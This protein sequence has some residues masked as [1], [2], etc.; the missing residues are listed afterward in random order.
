MTDKPQKQATAETNHSKSSL[1]NPQYQCL[2]ELLVN[3]YS[4][5]VMEK[6]CLTI[7]YVEGG[8][9]HIWSHFAVCT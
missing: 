5:H 4:Y 3:V 8:F 7:V 2:P 1:G 9:S 6:A